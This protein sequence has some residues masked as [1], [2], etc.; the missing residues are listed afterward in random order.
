VI[1][2]S[3]PHLLTPL[4]AASAARLLGRPW[5]FEVRDFWPSSLVDLGAL[6][7]GSRAHRALEALERRL[8]RRADAIV[9]VPP[10]GQERLAE[11]GV[12]PREFAHIPNSTD[13]ERTSS[14]PLPPTLIEA[15]RDLGERLVIVYAGALGVAQDLPVVLD[16]VAELRT[17]DPEVYERVG[18]LF[19]GDGVDR[20]AAES[21]AQ[22]LGLHSVRFHGPV[23][24]AVVS[25]VLERADACLL[26]LASADVFKYGLSPNKLFD[27]FAAGKPVLI[28]ADHPTIVD[29]SDAGIRYRAADPAAFAKAV[30]QM[31]QLPPD[32]RAAMGKRGR[33]LVRTRYSVS[34]VTDQYEELLQRVVAQHRA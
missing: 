4:A 21:R 15:F 1:I 32:R 25:T 14:A 31:A 19:V 2:G 11:V 30:A 6:R 7:A 26:T 34:A 10:V 29:E 27:Y 33:E 22:E 13:S 12:T 8:Y 5:V 24:K 17:N 3:S 28:A 18:F 16:G 23:D 20:G 9:S